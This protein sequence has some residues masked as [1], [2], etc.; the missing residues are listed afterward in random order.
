[1]I[2]IPLVF[3]I[4]YPLNRIL[5]IKCFFCLGLVSS[6]ISRSHQLF[7]MQK[8]SCNSLV[9]S[10]QIQSIIDLSISVL[11]ISIQLGLANSPM[12]TFHICSFN[13][14]S[15]TLSLEFYRK[16]NWLITAQSLAATG[17]QNK[18]SYLRLYPSDPTLELILILGGSHKLC[19]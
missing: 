1:M 7:L 13:D 14:F 16:G 15:C 9:L 12:K 2:Y 19:K 5:T 18:Q 3:S 4:R 10:Q 6:T 8:C 11:R 17:Y